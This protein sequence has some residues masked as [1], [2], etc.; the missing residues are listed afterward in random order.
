MEGQRSNKAWAQTGVG[1]HLSVLGRHL[2]MQL[3]IWV[4]T[5][6]PRA[7]SC[8]RFLQPKPKAA[9]LPISK[10]EACTQEVG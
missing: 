4:L 1:H 7:A 9:D 3:Q 5:I 6:G 10:I 2:H 8:S